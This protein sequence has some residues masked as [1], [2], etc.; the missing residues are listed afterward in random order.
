MMRGLGVASIGYS[1][2]QTSTR[3]AAHAASSATVRA[4]CTRSPEAVRVVLMTTKTS[5]DSTR[6]VSH[7]IFCRIQ[8]SFTT[9]G[10]QAKKAPLGRESGFHR[11]VN[12]RRPAGLKPYSVRGVGLVYGGIP[13]PYALFSNDAK[14][15]KAYPT[16]A[17]V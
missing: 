5:G 6:G 17:D 14:L 11:G 10:L 13:M 2:E 8:D 16:E 4:I 12:R 9:Q 1:Q 15:S 7:D 3:F